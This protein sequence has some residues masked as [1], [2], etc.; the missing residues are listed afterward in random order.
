[1]PVHIKNLTSGP[2]FVPLSSGGNLRISGRTVSGALP[3]IDVKNNPKIEKLLRQH[4]IV[5]EPHLEHAGERAGEAGGEEEMDDKG[6][7]TAARTR[8]KH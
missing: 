7:G 5:V 4:A 2:L 3:D 1:M 6:G 8:K